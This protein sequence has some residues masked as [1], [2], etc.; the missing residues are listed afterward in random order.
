LTRTR[1]PVSGTYGGLTA[2][3]VSVALSMQSVYASPCPPVWIANCAVDSV[4][5]AVKKY[6]NCW[7]VPVTV[8][9]CSS[10]VV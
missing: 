7:V 4:S 10:H 9:R 6:S 8:G 5:P 2:P 1:G 3:P